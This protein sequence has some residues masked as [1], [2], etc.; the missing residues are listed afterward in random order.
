MNMNLL[1][2]L[3]KNRI[4]GHV[5]TFSSPALRCTCFNKPEGRL[6]K[7]RG[8]GSFLSK[9]MNSEPTRGSFPLQQPPNLGSTGLYRCKVPELM[10]DLYNRFCY[11]TIRMKLGKNG[12]VFRWSSVFQH[13]LL[14]T[15]ERGVSGSF[16]SRSKQCSIILS[17]V[18]I[19]LPCL[20]HTYQAQI[21]LVIQ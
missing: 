5:D 21:D 3:R 8:I 14:F 4:S 11:K 20:L 7:L 12:Q 6:A 2:L 10:V 17:C 1:N 16:I 15:V 13:V 19:F 18:K 9:K